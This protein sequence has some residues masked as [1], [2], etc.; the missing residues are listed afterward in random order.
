MQV[1]LFKDFFIFTTHMLVTNLNINHIIVSLY[2]KM[3]ILCDRCWIK[4]IHSIVPI[5]LITTPRFTTLKP[6]NEN[7]RFTFCK[8]NQGTNWMTLGFGSHQPQNLLKLFSYCDNHILLNLP[9]TYRQ[10]FQIIGFYFHD[11]FF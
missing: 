6:L 4:T 8:H 11:M 3:K 5:K 1:N 7:K 10:L 2:Y 9:H